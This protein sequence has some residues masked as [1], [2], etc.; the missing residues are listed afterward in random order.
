MTL[1]SQG[2][3]LTSWLASPPFFDS[4]ARVIRREG[5]GVQD[6]VFLAVR[7]AD[8]PPEHASLLGGGRFDQVLERADMGIDA[9]PTQNVAH[10][11]DREPAVPRQSVEL[12]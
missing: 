5:V 12:P 10:L 8:I 6:S 3:R 1:T 7:V 11:S 4:V 2:P 9:E